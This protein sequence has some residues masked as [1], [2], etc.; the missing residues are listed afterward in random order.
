[1]ALHRFFQGHFLLYYRQFFFKL[2]GKD[3]NLHKKKVVS[4]IILGGDILSKPKYLFISKENCD[5][6]NSLNI[7]VNC[8][9]LKNWARDL[10]FFVGD[11]HTQYNGKMHEMECKS[12][13]VVF[14]AT[15]VQ[16]IYIYRLELHW[17]FG[18]HWQLIKI[19]LQDTIVK[20]ILSNYNLQIQCF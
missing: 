15:L 9:D 6:T 14:W 13:K 2:S 8:A 7:Q 4:Q 10:I 19:W 18:N 11:H 16:A 3:H 17:S 12:K 5:Y 1:M 20:L